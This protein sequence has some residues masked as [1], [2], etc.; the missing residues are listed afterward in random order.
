M[1]SYP[2]HGDY[3][4]VVSAAMS[5]ELSNLLQLV[6]KSS[7]LPSYVPQ[8]LEDPS[9]Q[10]RP[11]TL[12]PNHNFSAQIECTIQSGNRESL[13]KYKALSYALGDANITRRII[14]EGCVFQATQNLES[15][16]RHVRCK[17]QAVTL[18]VDA[19]CVS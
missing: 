2:S 12:L 17:E 16:L 19:I 18:W 13:P 8:P 14:I 1:V 10:L 5:D 7:D 11:I 9:R 6:A 15:A 4:T 3:H